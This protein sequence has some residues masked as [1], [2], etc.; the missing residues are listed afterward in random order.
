MSNHKNQEQISKIEKVAN[1]ILNT[2]EAG[3]NY[4][5]TNFDLYS[6]EQNILL[7]DGTLIGKF[8]MS[9]RVLNQ[10]WINVQQVH[11]DVKLTVKGKTAKFEVSV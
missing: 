6:T 8:P 1:V 4:Q 3:Q 7:V 10:V 5:G 2:A 9:T 11:P